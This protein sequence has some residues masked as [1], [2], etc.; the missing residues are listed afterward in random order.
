MLILFFIG[1][2]AGSTAGGIKIIR[3]QTFIRI[4]F[5]KIESIF[6]PDTVREYRIGS[7]IIDP[8]TAMTV[9]CFILIVIS[10]TLLSTFALVLNK[11]DPETALSTVSCMINN[12]GFAFRMAGPTESFAFLSNFGKLLSCF[13]MIAGRLEFFAILIAFV[14]AFWRTS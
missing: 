6:R 8:K 10:L 12:V 5:N 11:V 7:S 2:M 9:L 1:G 3:E 14:P 4:M 13:L